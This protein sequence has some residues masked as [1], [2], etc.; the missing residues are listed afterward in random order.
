MPHPGTTT[1][2]ASPLRFMRMFGKGFAETER[3][4]CQIQRE[5]VCVLSLVFRR[6][7]KGK[8]TF[9]VN[10]NAVVFQAKATR[11]KDI[12][13]FLFRFH[14]PRFEPNAPYP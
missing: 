7:V 11:I 1:A 4:V 6:S 12:P 14:P 10:G 2:G 8:E 9:V 5:D 3:G 13:F